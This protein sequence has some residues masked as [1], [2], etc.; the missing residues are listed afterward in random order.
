MVSKQT[1]ILW[2]LLVAIVLLPLIK[3]LGLPLGHSPEGEAAYQAVESIPSGSAVIM[4]LS[5]AP[6]SEG[7]LWPMALAIAR[8]H[9][10][11]GHHIITTTFSPDGIMYADKIKT[12]SEEEYGY[13][14]GADLIIL[15]YRAGGETALVAMADDMK[16]AYDTDYYGAALS[17]MPLWKSVQN[18]EGIS[19]V[20]TYTAG[21]NH[22]WLVRHIWAKHGVPCLGGVIALSAPEAIVY[23]QNG[24]LTGLISGVKGAAYYETKLGQPG[25]A[26]Q[27]M[28][29]QSLG[30][31]YLLV[32]MILGNIVFWM[33][34]KNTD[35]THAQE[36]IPHVN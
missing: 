14:Y 16:K 33:K 27:S 36:A 18:I 7:E 22:L 8:H 25:L 32:L 31:G 2:I 34:K 30:H 21:D 9:M 28:D 15:P 10:E 20:S 35:P 6:S 12:V 17:S 24:Q 23:F 13:V 11:K 29:A 4:D 19:L 1:H 5:I 26:V 3:P